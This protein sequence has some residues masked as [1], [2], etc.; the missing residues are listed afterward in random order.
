MTL[1][2]DDQLEKLKAIGVI[3]RKA[4][5]AME[6]AIEPGMTTAEL[7]EIGA[8]VLESHGARSAPQLAYDFP[9]ATCISVNDEVAHG[10]AGP[11]VLQDGDMI[12]IDVS[13]EK[14]SLFADTGRSSIVGKGTPEL[15]ELCAAT[16]ATLRKAI[17]A[18][19][20]GVRVNQIGRVVEREARKHGYNTI[21][22]LSGHGVGASIHE[23]PN[24]PN[25]NDPNAREKLHR[26]H[27][28]AIEPFLT[29]GIGEIFEM[30][31]G[32]TLKST[33]GAIAAQ[34]EHTVVITKG[35]P[36]IIT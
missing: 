22:E 16:K 28:I 7:D 23:E 9:S 12:N 26:G 8:A 14:D 36:L 18:A 2:N 31:D 33:D 29:K 32:W 19:R 27:V 6:Q 20:A 13:A 3:V 15:E 30:D 25:Y 17:Y 24:I 5:D 34:Y 10:I 4:I 35:A 21:R 1:E 11:R